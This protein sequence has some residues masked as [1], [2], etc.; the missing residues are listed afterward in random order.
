MADDKPYINVKIFGYN[1]QEL[2]NR[3]VDLETVLKGMGFPEVEITDIPSDWPSVDLIQ[4]VLSTTLVTF[5]VPR[6]STPIQNY[7]HLQRKFTL[8]LPQVISKIDSQNEE[9]AN[10]EVNETRNKRDKKDTDSG[11]ND[12]R[13]GDDNEE[14]YES[15]DTS[16]MISEQISE[17]IK[18]IQ[19]SESLRNSS[20]RVVHPADDNLDLSYVEITEQNVNGED[21]TEKMDDVGSIEVIQ[22]HSE[23]KEEEEEGRMEEETEE[24]SSRKQNT[25]GTL[26]NFHCKFPKC[27]KKIRWKPKYGRTR[28]F[29]HVL[30]HCKKHCFKCQICKQ[31]F[32]TTRQVRYHYGKNHTK[33]KLPEI[34]V[35]RLTSLVEGF[36]GIATK[37]FGDQASLFQ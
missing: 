25:S 7:V 30:L 15:K 14:D 26:M 20:K 2:K 12:E 22:N 1:L 32:K 4:P 35:K 17:P 29:D 5:N 27:G 10:F 11:E 37:C 6:Y 23:D 21:E 24:D 18:S 31:K 13:G 16:M 34:N 9:E 28:L 33:A 8:N 36:E 3:R 19:Q